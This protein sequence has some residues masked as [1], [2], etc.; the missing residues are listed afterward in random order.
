MRLIDAD[1][2]IEHLWRDDVSSREKI[3]SI[4]ERRPT[5]DIESET[6]RELRRIANGIN[7]ILKG[8]QHENT[9]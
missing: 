7:K 4:V 8:G 2:L 9:V 1:E 5:I 6:K 3:V